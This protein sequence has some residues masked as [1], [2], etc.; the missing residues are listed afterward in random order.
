MLDEMSSLYSFNIH[1]YYHTDWPLTTYM[2][3]YLNR[4]NRPLAFLY[5][6]EA[7]L[8]E[9]Y[10]NS[11]HNTD[12]ETFR[13]SVTFYVPSTKFEQH[14]QESPVWKLGN[15]GKRNI[16]PNGLPNQDNGEGIAEDGEVEG[17]GEGEEAMYDGPEKLLLRTKYLTDPGSRDTEELRA[18][19]SSA[20]EM[21]DVSSGC[22]S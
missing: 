11:S 13:A 10:V 12:P 7:K 2:Y 14:I 17:E 15:V 16:A 8:K 5:A 9:V 22:M 20:P 3:I 1:I 18:W 4:T 21:K 19:A 6:V